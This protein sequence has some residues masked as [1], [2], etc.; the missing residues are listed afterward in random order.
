MCTGS[1]TQRAKET[2]IEMLWSFACYDLLLYIYIHQLV[3]DYVSW[4]WW[5]CWL[6]QSCASWRI[7]T[8]F[9]ILF[10]RVDCKHVHL[11]FLWILG[12]F[13][14][15]PIPQLRTKSSN[16]LFG[17]IADLQLKSQNYVARHFWLALMFVVP[18]NELCLCVV[19]I[20]SSLSVLSC[21]ND[22]IC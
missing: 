14:V 15:D 8:G 13:G 6:W 16:F 20:M 18:I 22:I 2:I 3:C 21:G 19:P 17:H 12:F 1:K 7:L 10:S 4:F 5:Q 9:D 11:P